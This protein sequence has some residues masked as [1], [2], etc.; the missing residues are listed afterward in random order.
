MKLKLKDFGMF[1]SKEFDF[2]TGLNI[3]TSDVN[4]KGKTTIRT[5]M[6]FILSGKAQDKDISDFIPNGTSKTP[7]ATLSNFYNFETLSRSTNPSNLITPSQVFKI[8]SRKKKDPIEELGVKPAVINFLCN[9]YNFFNL[10]PEQQYEILVDYLGNSSF[11]PSEYIDIPDNIIAD[12]PTQISTKDIQVLYD[13]FYA[14]R[15]NCTRDINTADDNIK[16]ITT[17]LSELPEVP[18]DVETKL[19]ELNA[20]KEKYK[21]LRQYNSVRRIEDELS[22]IK[23]SVAISKFPEELKKE[24]DDITKKGLENKVK[25]DQ[26]QKFSGSCPFVSSIQCQSKEEIKKYIDSLILDNDSLRVRGKQLFEQKQKAEQDAEK[27]KEIKVQNIR[28]RLENEIKLIEVE[29]KEIEIF[30]SD[31]DKRNESIDIEMFRINNLKFVSRDI[32]NLNSQL[33]FQLNSKEKSSKRKE[34]LEKLVD[35]F[36]KDGIK[37][38]IVKSGAKSFIDNINKFSSSF[39]VKFDV[40]TEPKFSLK[41]NDKTSKMLSEAEKLISSIS[42]QFAIAKLSK[43]NFIIV[44]RADC[45]DDSNLKNLCDALAREEVIS[46][47]AGT[48]LKDRISREDCVVF[49]L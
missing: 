1:E 15:T 3:L 4:A 14:E 37:S 27:E 29:N 17:K 42:I 11:N 35:I 46:I 36:G 22:T 43:Y 21:E 13:K 45:L 28:E 18:N 6:E 7:T 26:A 39:G 16:Q 2:E 30:N 20:K 40:L 32:K 5:A 38:K 10:T 41:I 44:D 23:N 31:V 33:E 48:K 47:I 25:I 9:G 12:V 8:D 34:Q 24:L 49:S 19:T